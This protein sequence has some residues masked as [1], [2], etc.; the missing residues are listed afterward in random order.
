[1]MMG[2]GIQM[3][4]AIACPVCGSKDGHNPGCLQVQLQRLLDQQKHIQCPEC[5]AMDVGVNNDDFY[6]C[7]QCHT[8]YTTGKNYADAD[9]KKAYLIL[10]MDAPIAQGVATVAILPTKGTGQ[11]RLDQEIEKIQEAIAEKPKKRRRRK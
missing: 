1:M 10:D 7:R 11:F 3:I 9:A 2:A 5:D 6:E 8:Q 4:I